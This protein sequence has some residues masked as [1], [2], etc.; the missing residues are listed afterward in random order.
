MA[1]SPTPDLE[2]ISAILADIRRDDQRASD[3]ILRLRDLLK[4][5][6]FEP[7]NIDLNETVDETIK[8]SSGLAIAR[9]VELVGVIRRWFC[10]SRATV[11]SFGRSS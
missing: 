4:R 6:P 9:K 1:K 2:E 10:Q 8:L 5:T 11:F 3:V 7:K